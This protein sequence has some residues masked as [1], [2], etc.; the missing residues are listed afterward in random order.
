VDPS[1]LKGDGSGRPAAGISDLLWS[2]LGQSVIIQE[3]VILNV[4]KLSGY[5]AEYVTDCI[6]SYSYRKLEAVEGG[7]DG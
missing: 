1:E 3:K 5:E 6:H 4:A 2:E 7:K